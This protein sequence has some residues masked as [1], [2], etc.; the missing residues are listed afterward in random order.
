MLSGHV[1]TTHLHDN[2]GG[3]DDHLVPFAG[4]IDWPAT[5]T[6]LYKIGY[7]GPLVFELPDHGNTDRVLRQA[8]TAR[9]RLQVILDEL[10]VP[11]SFGEG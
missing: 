6:A 9:E 5:M 8:V 3:S 1:I 11:M 4:T 7:T 10:E 2:R